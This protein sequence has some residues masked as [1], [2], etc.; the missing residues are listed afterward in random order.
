MTGTS[1][2]T[3]SSTTTEANQKNKKSSLTRETPTNA[4]SKATSLNK[5]STRMLMNFT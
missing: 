4:H 1:T 5:R 3:T 2:N